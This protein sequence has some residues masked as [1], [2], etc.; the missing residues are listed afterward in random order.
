MKLKFYK[1][2]TPNALLGR[3]TTILIHVYHHVTSQMKFAFN[4]IINCFKIDNRLVIYFVMLKEHYK[5]F[6][7]I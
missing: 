2:T 5:L 7:L 4:H 6:D 3:K 1:I